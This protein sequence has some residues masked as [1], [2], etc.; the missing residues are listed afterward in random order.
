MLS[1][2]DESH[3]MVIRLF[4]IVNN[5]SHNLKCQLQKLYIQT[6]ATR[7]NVKTASY[8]QWYKTFLSHNYGKVIQN[9]QD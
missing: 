4:N 1:H 8:T 6:L 3:M 7:R 2:Y 5:Y 9:T